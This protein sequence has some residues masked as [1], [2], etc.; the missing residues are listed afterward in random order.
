MP[1]RSQIESPRRIMA[2]TSPRALDV[3]ARNMLRTLRNTRALLAGL[4]ACACIIMPLAALDLRFGDAIPEEHLLPYQTLMPVLVG[5]RLLMARAFG[6]YDFRHRLT[7]GD[8][9]FN[10]CGAALLGVLGGYLVMAVLQLYYAPATQLSRSVAFFDLTGLIIWYALSRRAVLNILYR[11][12]YRVRVILVGAREPCRA[13]AEEIREHAPPLLE[14]VGYCSSEAAGSD[15]DYAGAVDELI[16]AMH[17]RGASAVL[18]VDSALSQRQLAD[19]LKYGDPE[20]IEL[21]Q[22]P[23]LDPS[24]LASTRVVGI[25]G[26]PVVP[27]HPAFLAS[28]YRPVKR[29]MDIVMAAIGLVFGL[30]G[31]LLVAVAIRMDTRGPVLFVQDRIGHRRRPF[32]A[33]KFRTMIVDAERDSGPV[34]AANPDPRVTRVGR[35][36]RKSRMDEYPQLWN[37]LRGDMSLVGPRPERPEFVEQ[38]L[39]ACPLYERRFLVKP[40][41]TGLA[42]I[43]GRYDTDYLHKLRYD[44][45]YINSL[46][47]LT[48]LQV[49]LATVRIVLTGKG[50]A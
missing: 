24:I 22:L 3:T 30:P 47:L 15:S 27:L 17:A 37:V 5:W 7:V 35:W 12:G 23:G 46:S 34:L 26:L 49:L 31:A 19:V 2:M 50:A 32:R 42:Q 4:D 9:F 10:A 8:F 45:I 14:V 33:Y 20:G 43:H 48:D 18:L 29:A 36:L 44:L 40:G 11:L 38:Y 21:L 39:A 6:L 28:L 13:V 1:V 16:P 25:A 41:L